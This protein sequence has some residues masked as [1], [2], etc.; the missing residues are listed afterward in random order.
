MNEPESKLEQAA[1]DFFVAIRTNPKLP[2]R[3]L[4]DSLVAELKAF[5]KGLKSGQAI[6]PMDAFLLV[7]IIDSCTEHAS[8][9]C[10]ATLK[11]MLEIQ[12]E[13]SETIRE[14]VFGM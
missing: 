8:N 5:G 7:D 4:V 6:E 11:G 9:G 13:L 1:C 14:D 12:A 2:D 3:K 10:Y